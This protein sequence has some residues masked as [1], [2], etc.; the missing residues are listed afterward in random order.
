MTIRDLQNAAEYQVKMGCKHLLESD[1]KETMLSW[2]YGTAA[3]V[4]F[5]KNENIIDEETHRKYKNM[6][7]RAHVDYYK[8]AESDFKLAHKRLF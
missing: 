2:Y 4:D 6:I 8:N 5:C 3:I 1:Y 7:E